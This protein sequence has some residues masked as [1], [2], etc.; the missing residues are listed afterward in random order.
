MLTHRPASPISASSRVTC[1]PDEIGSIATRPITTAIVESAITAVNAVR[2]VRLR[3]SGSRWS[4][5]NRNIAVVRPN[6]HTIDA[7]ALAAITVSTWPNPAW[8]TYC[9]LV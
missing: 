7:S 3:A 8:L 1:R 4:Q 5:Q 2:I 9:G 6:W